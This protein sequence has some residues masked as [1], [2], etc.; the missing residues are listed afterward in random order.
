MTDPT[1][2]PLDGLHHKQDTAS[3]TVSASGGTIKL[4]ISRS[5]PNSVRAE[6]NLAGAIRRLDTDGQRFD[7]E[8]VDVFAEP[9]RAVLDGVIVTPTLVITD[10]GLRR[11]LVGDLTNVGMLDLLLGSPKP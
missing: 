6:A 3:A 11:I 8:I 10:A 2:L 9:K 1:S 4:Y 5:T 7:V